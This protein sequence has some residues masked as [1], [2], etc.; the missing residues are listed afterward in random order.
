M[1][2]FNRQKNW[3]LFLRFLMRTCTHIKMAEGWLK[4]RKSC[5]VGPYLPL[6]TTLTPP[7]MF[8][9]LNPNGLSPSLTVTIP[10]T[11]S[12]IRTNGLPSPLSLFWNPKS[13][14]PLSHSLIVTIPPTKLKTRTNGHHSSLYLCLSLSGMA[15]LIAWMSTQGFPMRSP[16]VVTQSGYFG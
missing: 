11:K 14:W 2:S 4:E 10:P 13:R 1:L 6:F 8:E 3:K 16:N 15:W 12:K 9:T 7:S 5:R